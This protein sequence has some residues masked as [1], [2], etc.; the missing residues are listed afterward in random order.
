MVAMDLPID[1]NSAS[2][3]TYADLVCAAIDDCGGDLVLVGHS[4]GGHIIPLVAARRPVRHLVYLCAY[5]PDVGRSFMDQ[6][7][8]EPV[9]LLPECYGAL[10]SDKQ[11]RMVW[12]DLEAARALMYADCD[13]SS[14][15]AAIKRL[16]PQSAYATTLPFSLPEFPTVS[17]TSIICSEDRLLGG[18]WAKLVARDRLGAK[19]VE[20]PGSHSPFLSRPQALAE[21]LLAIA[22]T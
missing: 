20:L 5:I 16:R 3:D 9:M 22:T 19:L 15:E 7:V 14:V 12:S 8:D 10:E 17:C 21:A 18:E 6:L 1:D 4:Y 13:E 11:S 2:F